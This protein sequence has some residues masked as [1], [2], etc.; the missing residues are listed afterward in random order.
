MPLVTINC[1]PGWRLPDTDDYNPATET[2][3]QLRAVYTMAYCLTQAVA[4]A[5]NQVDSEE[6]LTPNQVLVNFGQIHGVAFNA[7]EVQILI[8]P[9]AGDPNAPTARQRRRRVEIHDYVH[10]AMVALINDLPADLHDWPGFDI[11]IMPTN[12][13][14]SNT[15]PDGEMRAAWDGVEKE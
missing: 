5:V 14:G 1:K 8:N 15:T 9:G 2:D 4:S 11:E 12:M 10:A 3:R 13:S 6:K 7:A